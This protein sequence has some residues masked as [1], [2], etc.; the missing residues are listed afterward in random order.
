MYVCGWVGAGGLL[1]VGAGVGAA[2]RVAP[3]LALATLTGNILQPTHLP[4]NLNLQP[5]VN[6]CLLQE[7]QLRARGPLSG[8]HRGGQPAAARGLP[9]R[10]CG[11]LRSGGS[12]QLPLGCT[13]QLRV[14]LNAN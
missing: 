1:A 8:R 2:A 6:P 4:F 11:V 7:L 12:G 10:R 9:L 5:W 13:G 3:L 14:H